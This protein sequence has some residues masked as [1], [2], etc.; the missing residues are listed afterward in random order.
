MKKYLLFFSLF[1]GCIPAFTQNGQ[2]KIDEAVLMAAQSGEEVEF[3]ILL[4]AQA[5]VH[6]ASQLNTK[7]GKAQ[8]VFQQLQATAQKTQ[9]QVIAT[10]Q[11]NH[12]AYA[13][14]YLVNL[15]WAE[16]DYRSFKRLLP[17]PKSQESPQIQQ[18]ILISLKR[19]R[20]S[21]NCVIQ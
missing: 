7:T 3:L 2:H 5:D 11:A 8:Y 6:Q 10:L 16:G 1:F 20:R 9:P 18:F 15:I 14:L 21:W 19:N 13:S 4:E 12:A 17:C